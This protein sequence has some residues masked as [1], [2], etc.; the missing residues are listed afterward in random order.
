ML[1]STLN[2][3]RSAGPPSPPERPSRADAPSALAI[4]FARS[5]GRPAAPGRGP[6][7]Y[8]AATWRTAAGSGPG[9]AAGTGVKL[10]AGL[11]EDLAHG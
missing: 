1:R 9:L 8:R 3:I 5:H 6:D 2:T 10:G 4:M 11:R 7:R